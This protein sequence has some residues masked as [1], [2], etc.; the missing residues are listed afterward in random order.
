[1][2]EKEKKQAHARERETQNKKT[3]QIYA[4]VYPQL[5]VGVCLK[6]GEDE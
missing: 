5:V 4:H 6:I 3:E 2:D 1:M